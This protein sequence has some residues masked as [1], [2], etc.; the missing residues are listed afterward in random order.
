MSKIDIDFP[1]PTKAQIEAFA[2]I[3]AATAHEAFDRGGAVDSAIKPIY[4]G[5]R[6]LGA[7]FTLSSPPLD[8]LTLHA[9]LK[10]AKPG[11]VLVCDATGF[12][13]QGLF[14]DVMAS[15]AVGRG[16][17]GLVVDGGV[18]DAST[19]REIGFPVFSRSIS[20]KGAV[21]ENLGTLA[22]PIVLG[23]L[24]VNPGDL[25]IGDDDGVTIIPLAQVDAVLEA[26]KAREEKEARFRAAL[27][28]GKTT[29][30]MLD[31]GAVL[32]RKGVE[33]DI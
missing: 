1:R 17:A 5:L 8:N 29:W 16:I 6:V 7:A 30:D 10:L 14:G 33:F 19:I 22:K 24:T 12:T 9:A 23:G 18:R 31:L 27:L 32:R 20:V 25:V 21:K 3:S 28:T 15:C 13:E 4:P 26:S 11:D 2:K